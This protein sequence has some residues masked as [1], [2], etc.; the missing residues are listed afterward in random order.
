M[1]TWN[2]L[3]PGHLLSANLEAERAL[4]AHIPMDDCVA[5]SPHAQAARLKQNSPGCGWPWLAASLRLRQNIEDARTL[6]GSLGLDF[7]DTWVQYGRVLQ[8]GA[9]ARLRRPFRVSR[10]E[11]ARRVYSMGHWQGVPEE[12]GGDPH[13]APVAATCVEV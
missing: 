4:L 1:P 9:G 2:E 3:R 5:E 13:A 10:S 12:A 6:P 11:L 7:Q 8:V